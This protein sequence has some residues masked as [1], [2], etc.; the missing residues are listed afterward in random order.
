VLDL[1]QNWEAL[2]A[3]F[4]ADP[5]LRGRV[6]HELQTRYQE[7]Q[8]AYHT[9]AHIQALL[10][11][12]Q[13]Y[14]GEFQDPLSVG[15]AIWFHDAIYNPR[16]GKNELYS[17]RLAKRQL[18]QMGAS[19]ALQERVAELVMATAGHKADPRDGDALLF[20][21]LDLSILGAEPEVYT[22]YLAQIRREYR[23]VPGFLY[24]RARLRFVRGW[25]ARPR[26]FMSEVGHA[27]WE[28]AARVNLA[29]E[30]GL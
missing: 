9:L 2:T 27:R 4:C 14:Q 16:K 3:S 29:G 11:L 19:A 28:A 15:L 18:G 22:A 20:L 8:R 25:L 21:D 1:K 7:P 26:L 6:Y 10:E 23:F 17:A 13:E 12:G 5:A 24:Q 30:L